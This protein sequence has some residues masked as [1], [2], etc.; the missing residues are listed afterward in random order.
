MKLRRGLA[1][2]AAVSS[3]VAFGIALNSDQPAHAVGVPA[4]G[5]YSFNQSGVSGVTWTISAICDQPS[6]TRNQAD[7]SD[8][9]T[10]AFHC[11]LNIVS[12]TPE[13][14]RHADKLQNF[15]GRARLSSV[16]WNFSLDVA[17][18]V[19]CPGGGTAASTERYDFDDATMTGT[20]T[21]LHDEECGLESAMTKQPFSLQLTGPPPSPVQRYPLYC[22][23]IAMCY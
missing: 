15:N 1:M 10:F 2:G 5:T 17:D 8:P 13:Q 18:G 23:G 14:I 19:T 12:S 11:F 3:A 21:S 7:Y 20:H 4:D 16:R 22:N 6:G 9:V